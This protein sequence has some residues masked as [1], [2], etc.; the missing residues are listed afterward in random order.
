MSNT[1]EYRIKFPITPEFFKKYMNHFP[2]LIILCDKSKIYN[3]YLK[4]I[5]LNYSREIQY[6][7]LNIKEADVII[8]YIIH[9]YIY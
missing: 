1:M 5:F 2:Y 6:F 8:L 7:K 3:K 9:L 4:T